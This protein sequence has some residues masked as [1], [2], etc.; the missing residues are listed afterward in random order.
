MKKLLLI[1]FLFGALLLAKTTKAQVAVKGAFVQDSLVI[2]DKV[3]FYLTARYPQNKVILFPD[4]TWQ[5][6]PYEYI[7]KRYFSTETKDSVSY[8]SAIY[9]LTSFEIDSAQ[10]LRLPVFQINPFDTTFYY[11]DTDT[12]HLKE[13][14]TQPL[15]DTLQAQNLPLKTNTD[16]QPVHWL[17]NYPVL[18]IVC[19]VLLPVAA[20]GWL[21]FG[22]KIRKK[23][24]VK[25]L[26]KAHQEFLQQFTA[27]EL[28]LQQQFSNKLAEQAASK[29][30]YYL[31][32]LDTNPYTKFTVKEL[33]KL[34][35][36]NDL[37][38][39][40][41]KL[42]AAVYGNNVDLHDSLT[43]LKSYAED[44]FR[45]KLNLLTHGK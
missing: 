6:A 12:L 1:F 32:N 34:I 2:G 35:P 31:E 23:Y 30:K 16:Y 9:E 41:K 4:S 44:V 3:F 40:L 29:W 28:T 15:P 36:N 22:E 43:F 8:D 42:D 7:A 5:Y 24:R 20:I 10:L 13:L 25:K 19:G 45:K 27:I 38:A 18:L 26:L 37:I 21:V 33:S 11:S 17:F 39:A 14:V